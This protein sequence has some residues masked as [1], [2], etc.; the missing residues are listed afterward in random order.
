MDIMLNI[1][2]KSMPLKIFFP[3]G[4]STKILGI[5]FVF[6]L[7]VDGYLFYQYYQQEKRIKESEQAE[8]IKIENEKTA[9]RINNLATEERIRV[10][11]EEIKT[12][13]GP[14]SFNEELSAF[15]GEV[16]EKG[17]DF[18]I[19]EGGG[20]TVRVEL[21]DQTK[22][23]EIP[24]VIENMSQFNEDPKLFDLV[25]LKNGDFVDVVGKYEKE[26]LLVAQSIIVY[27]NYKK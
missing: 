13:G 26:G 17:E 22:A 8:I 12:N 24:W 15:S 14:R 20:K 18:L 3:S 11:K 25:Y 27:K 4:K 2:N 5:V 10:A 21:N 6:F 16:K 19:L 9:S 1:N 7:F 23:W